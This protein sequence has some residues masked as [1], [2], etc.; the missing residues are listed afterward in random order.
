MVNIN[1]LKQTAVCTTFHFSSELPGFT[2]ALVNLLTELM[3]RRVPCIYTNFSS[4]SEVNIF[5]RLEN[6]YSYVGKFPSHALA[7]VS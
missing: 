1:K 3:L 2:A 7:E 5:L 4:L 6:T